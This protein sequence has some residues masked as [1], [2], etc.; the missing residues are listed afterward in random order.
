M[1]MM[2][3][4]DPIAEKIMD[5]SKA[6]ADM[7]PN[8]MLDKLVWVNMGG[9][10]TKRAG[11]MDNSKR[12]QA[13]RPNVTMT[14]AINDFTNFFFKDTQNTRL[15][16]IYM[17]LTN[18]MWPRDAEFINKIFLGGV[19]MDQKSVAIYAG[20]RMVSIGDRQERIF[21]L[22]VIDEKPKQ[23][24]T[25]RKYTRKTATSKTETTTKKEQETND[26]QE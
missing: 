12:S 2:E 24:T 20:D 22:P 8:D 23:K 9:Y 17:R 26:E 3:K 19:K 6:I 4:M 7:E 1:N 21:V 11:R 25:K 15:N 14:R 18:Q 5:D 16:D 10:K 13:E